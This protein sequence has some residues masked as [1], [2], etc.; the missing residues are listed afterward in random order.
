MQYIQKMCNLDSITP[1]ATESL[2]NAIQL[3]FRSTS[4][5]RE[6][7]CRLVCLAIYLGILEVLPIYGI[8]VPATYVLDR[9]NNPQE[10]WDFILQQQNT[11]GIWLKHKALRPRCTEFSGW[12]KRSVKD[13][14]VFFFL[15]DYCRLDTYLNID[16]CVGG[17]SNKNPDQVLQWFQ[18]LFE[19]K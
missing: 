18:T 5:Y 7:L 6:H 3:H 4:T 2:C 19:V 13:G 9:L 16:A 12:N 17:L 15:P 14:G 1:N 11:Y 10:F 8:C